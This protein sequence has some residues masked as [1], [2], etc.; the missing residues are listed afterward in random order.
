MRALYNL[1]KKDRGFRVMKYYSEEEIK[2]IR[3]ALE[4]EVLGWSQVSTK[5][6]FGCPCYKVS[7]KL[8]VFL[9]TKGI[10]FTHLDQTDKEHLSQE[11]ELDFFNTGKKKIKNWP[12]VSIQSVEELK[13]IM[14]Y[15]R[16]SY[17]RALN[18]A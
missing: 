13:A 9:V 10:V 12:Q 1:N 8:F 5:K 3:I 11:Y 14:P 6:M 18:E 7:N 16:K 4:K 15:A 2:E 17:K